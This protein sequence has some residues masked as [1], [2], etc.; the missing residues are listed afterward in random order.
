MVGRRPIKTEICGPIPKPAA[1]MAQQLNKVFLGD[2]PADMRRYL[3]AAL[4][5][6]KPR[7]PRIV[8]PAVGQFTLAKCAIEAGYERENIFTSDISMFSS[9][10]GHLYAGRP[11]D[12]LGFELAEEYRERYAACADEAERAAFLFWVMKTCQ[13]DASVFFERVPLDDLRERRET[14]VRKLANR[15]RSFRDYYGGI[16]YEVADMRSVLSNEHPDGTLVVVNPPVFRGGYGKMF[17]FGDTLR[18]DP[19]IPEFD[20]SK[21]YAALYAH[22][23]TLKTPFVWYRFRSAKGFSPDEVVFC[24]EWDVDKRDY[25]L[26]TKPEILDGFQYRSSVDFMAAKGVRPYAAPVFTNGDELT[27][28]SEIRFVQ[29]PEAQALYY[30]DLFAHKLGNTRAEQYFLMLMDGKVFATVGFMTNKL[31]GLKSDRV[32]ENY[33]FNASVRNLP[34]ANRL[35]MLAITSRAFADILYRTAS[36]VNRVYRLRGLRTTCLSKYRRVKLN[37]GILKALE[38][39]RLPTGKANGGMYRILYDAEFRDQDFQ[40]VV[41]QFLDEERALVPA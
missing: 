34:R 39:E 5:H 2:T 37:N 10:L 36:R 32:F 12:E 35:L 27:C 19:Q 11:I 7:Y 41:R 17:D 23:K 22:T 29:V 26:L 28:D 20:F 21:E 4:R 8:L 30:R 14:H 6:L 1:N 15:L 25:W 9:A 13:L 40:G 3:A 18:F 24:K 16:R 31:F 33:G 38:C